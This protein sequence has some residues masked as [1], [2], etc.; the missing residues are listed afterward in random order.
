MKKITE[1]AH[2]LLMPYIHDQ[3]ICADFTLGNGHDTEFLAQQAVNG[4]VYAFDIQDEALKKSME[5]LGERD[6]VKLILD[7]HINL[8]Q[9]IHTKLDAAVFN[10]GYLPNGDSTFTTKP[11]DSLC[12]VQKAFLCCKKHAL[13][14]LVFY[15]GH[16]LGKIEAE[17]ITAWCESLANQTARIMRIEMVN[18][19]NAPFIYAI[20]KL[21]ED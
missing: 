19:P 10:F 6:N 20:E 15:P 7:N 14:V 2:D 9:Y 17:S 16:D 11:Q 13:L 21:L 18:K 4:M 5:L 1:M 12:A 3:A 8:D